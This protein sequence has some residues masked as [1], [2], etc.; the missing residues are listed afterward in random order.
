MYLFSHVQ[1]LGFPSHHYSDFLGRRIEAK[2]MSNKTNKAAG[3]NC[4]RLNLMFFRSRRNF[5]KQVS[6]SCTVINPLSFSGA[7]SYL[8]NEAHTS[9]EKVTSLMSL[10]SLL[11]PI[12]YENIFPLEQSPP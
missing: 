2:K 12:T 3:G 10:S 9:W 7:H 8:L 1:F 5:N 11:R 6:T 4:I